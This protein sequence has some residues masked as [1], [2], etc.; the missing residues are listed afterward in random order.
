M[1]FLN[2]NQGYN[3]ELMEKC[4]T[5]R[6]YSA[7]V[8]RIRSYADKET[9]IEEAVDRAVTECIEDARPESGGSENNKLDSLL[10]SLQFVT[11]CHKLHIAEPNLKFGSRSST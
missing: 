1:R 11:K 9:A 4:R 7:F 5:L 8:A 6:E 2:I 3:Q 10:F